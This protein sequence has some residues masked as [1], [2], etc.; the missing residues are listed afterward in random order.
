MPGQG[1]RSH[2]ATRS[3][4]WRPV[5]YTADVLHSRTDAMPD[6]AMPKYRPFPRGH[7]P[8]CTRRKAV[9]TWLAA[10]GLGIAA[11]AA[12][13]PALAAGVAGS[14]PTRPVRFV[15]PFAPGGSTDTLAR[16]RG[17]RLADALGQP[18]HQRL[19]RVRARR[20]RR[21]KHQ[22]SRSVGHV[23]PI[24]EDHVEVHAQIQRRA[25]ALDQRDRTRVTRSTPHS[26]TGLQMT[27][28]RAV[29]HTEYFGEH[30]RTGDQQKPQRH[31]Q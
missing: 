30:R 7:R 23:H 4:C 29:H 8:T 13:A 27:R 18:L 14:F 28:D 6:T 26:R 10:A 24:D 16:V 17:G 31:R 2:A 3:K 11:C 12:A 25:E 20:S 9:H 1:R 22:L 21:A 15:V 5:Q 19:Q